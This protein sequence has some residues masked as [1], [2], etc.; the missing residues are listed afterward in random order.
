MSTIPFRAR[1]FALLLAV[2]LTSV[3]LSVSLALLDVAY[4]QVLL[5]STARQSQYAFYAADSALECALYQDEKNN[6]FDF[7]AEPLVAGTFSCQGQTVTYTPAA[8]V[9]GSRTTTFTIPCAG[10]GSRSA[11]TIYKTSPTGTIIDAVGFSSC[12]AADPNRT[13]RG[14]KAYY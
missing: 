13:E 5:G 11:A 1:G 4:K 12:N 7:V 10:G 14:E 8:A 9:S 2:I 6:L 3:I